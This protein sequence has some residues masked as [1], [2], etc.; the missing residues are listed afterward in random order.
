MV[1]SCV[2]TFFAKWDW[3]LPYES[4]LCYILVGLGGI[5]EKILYTSFDLEEFLG[6]PFLPVFFPLFK[7][8]IYLNSY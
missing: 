2:L 6:M 5:T 1:K 8:L 7:K 4:E 3:L